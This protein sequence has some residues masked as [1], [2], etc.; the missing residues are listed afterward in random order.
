MD[1]QTQDI[2]AM[3]EADLI[4]CMAAAQSAIGDVERDETARIQSAKANYSYSYI[5]ESRIYQNVRR[6]LSPMGVA[7]FVSCVDRKTQNGTTWVAIEIRFRKGDETE[8]IRGEAQGDDPGDKGYNKAMTTAV[9]IALT[10]QFL[11]GGDVDPEQ[12]AH[13]LPAPAG[14]PKLSTAA[15]K[16][17]TTKAMDCGVTTSDGAL[18]QRM[19]LRIASFVRGEQQTRLDE[20][21]ASTVSALVDGADGKTPRL[22]GYA[23][24]P[25]K[26]TAAIVEREIEEKWEWKS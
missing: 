5:S 18:D 2:E 21:P 13:E 11:Q 22:D 17:L 6:V 26:A 14:P 3:Y 24:D 15:L 10:K 23:A 9:R 1:A 25:E 7:I 16:R 4:S 19:L 8:T 12:I 20:I